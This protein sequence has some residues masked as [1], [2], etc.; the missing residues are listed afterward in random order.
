MG[1]RRASMNYVACQGRSP[2]HGRGCRCTPLEKKLVTNLK[3]WTYMHPLSPT[4]CTPSAH[5]QVAS[6]RQLVNQCMF[7]FLSLHLPSLFVLS[8]AYC[9][10]A[11]GPA[12]RYFAV[13]SPLHSAY[14]AT[15]GQAPLVVSATRPA[16]QPSRSLAAPCRRVL[17]SCSMSAYVGLQSAGTSPGPRSLPISIVDSSMDRR[18]IVL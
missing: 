11:T 10:Q 7:T 4:Y 13:R 2:V 17:Y 6:H 16:V 14:K 9:V 8:S 15:S 1:Q 18:T 5:W 12:G 3:F